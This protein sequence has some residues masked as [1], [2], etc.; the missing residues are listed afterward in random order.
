[1]NTEIILFISNY[2]DIVLFLIL[3]IVEFKNYTSNAVK[4][5]ISISI[6]HHSVIHV[7][8][9]HHLDVKTFCLF[10]KVLLG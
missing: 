8:K 3:F 1:M 2:Y 9:N 6:I 7:L 10:G 4:V 5:F